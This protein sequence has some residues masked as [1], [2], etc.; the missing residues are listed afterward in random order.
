MDRC[1]IYQQVEVNVNTWED[2]YSDGMEAGVERRRELE[3]RCRQ[4]G[5]II[6]QLSFLVA[7][8]GLFLLARQ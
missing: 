5:A 7:M 4:Y 8:L 3:T 2:G 1:T 6:L